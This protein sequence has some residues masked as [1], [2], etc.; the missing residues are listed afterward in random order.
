MMLP[1]TGD[2]P[3]DPARCAS[4]TG[5]TA[6]VE[7][8]QLAVLG[9]DRREVELVRVLAEAGARLRV[10]GLPPA[11]VP[12]VQP[13]SDPIAAVTGVRAVIAPMSGADAQ[14]YLPTPLVRDVTIRLDERLFAA[15]GRKTPLFI[16]VLNPMQA[17]VAAA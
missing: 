8:L 5:V 2:V 14:G 12:E 6:L 13:L 4:G 15:I 9:G 11:D 3:D 7:R 1:Y 10:V 17:P 16:G